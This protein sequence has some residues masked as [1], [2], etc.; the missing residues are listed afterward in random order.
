M[1]EDRAARV[2]DRLLASGVDVE[3]AGLKL[4]EKRGGGGHASDLDARLTFDGAAY[5]VRNGLLGAARRADA[6]AVGWA[7][8]LKGGRVDL[9]EFPEALATRLAGL[10]VG[11]CVVCFAGN[12]LAL[13]KGPTRAVTVMVGAEDLERLRAC[14]E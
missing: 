8:L 6:D 1:L 3:Y 9:D 10:A 12:S 7:R 11:S 4:L 14:G 5:L 13:W 2:L